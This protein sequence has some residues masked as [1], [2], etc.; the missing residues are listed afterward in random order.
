ME[1]F[2]NLIKGKQP[3]LVE[4]YAQWCPHCQRMNPIIKQM[5]Y[6]W[7]DKVNVLKFDI[8]EP[9]SQR[10]IEYYQIQ[11]IPTMILFKE[12]EQL[13]R[14]SGEM[15]EESLNRLLERNL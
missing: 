4:F 7:T 1:V 12:G 10:L 15:P 6:K 5:E 13:W 8:D 9:K 14:Q 11:S 3:V 2:H